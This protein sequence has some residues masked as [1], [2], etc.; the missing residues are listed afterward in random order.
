[1]KQGPMRGY[2]GKAN[3]ETRIIFIPAYATDKSIYD[4]LRLEQNILNRSI[5]TNW[6]PVNKRYTL[7]DYAQ[8]YIDTFNITENDIIVGTSLGG[9]LA[10]EIQKLISL[11]AIITLSNIKHKDEQPIL[12]I[13]LRKTRLYK[14]L[15]GGFL[16]STLNIIAPFYG[17][18]ISAFR[19]FEQV[20]KATPNEFLEWGLEK[21]IFW[22]NEMIPENLV[23][24][25]GTRDPLFP[26]YKLKSCDHKIKKGS[27]AMVR[28]RP[29]EI[30]AILNRR[31][32]SYLQ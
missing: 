26:F 4:N 20:F 27:H 13:F 30:S 11:K 6:L 12:F 19:W 10:I 31:L 16:K 2:P 15:K 5:F 7:S 1:M 18:R 14:L 3:M 24:I 23:H 17:S 8:K 25:H 28:F 21:S 9:M 29:D 32:N 22:E